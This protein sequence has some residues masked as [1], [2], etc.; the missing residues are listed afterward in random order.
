MWIGIY[1]ILIGGSAAYAAHLY[2]QHDTD[3]LPAGYIELTLDKERY[4]VGDTV[5][6]TVVNRFPTVIYVVNHCPKEPLNVYAWKSNQWEQLHAFA[7]ESGQCF[8]QERM[9]AIPPNGSRGYN[10]DDWQTLFAEPGVYRIAMV[11]DGYSEIPFVDFVVAEKPEVIYLEEPS[12]KMPTPSLPSITGPEPE[13]IVTPVEEDSVRE[14]E[15]VFNTEENEYEREYEDEHE[16]EW[17]DD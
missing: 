10:F 17:D 13:I 15:D 3:K 2:K 12:V 5:S 8:G 9:V 7:D 14:I 11:V 16:E 6:F 4:I 1:V